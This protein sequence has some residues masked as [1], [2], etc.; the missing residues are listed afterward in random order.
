[1]LFIWYKDCQSLG[2]RAKII[3]IS[4]K[5]DVEEIKKQGKYKTNSKLTPSPKN[6]N[7]NNL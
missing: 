1:M 4:F 3:I 6:S 2:I 7:K 5:E